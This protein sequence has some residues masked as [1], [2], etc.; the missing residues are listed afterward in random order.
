MERDIEGQA[1]YVSTTSEHEVSGWAVG[2]ITFAA[3]MMMLMG[4]FHIF[5]GL[6]G[7]FNDAFYETPREYFTEFSVSSWGWIQLVAGI[8]VFAAGVAILGGSVWARMVGVL[9]ALLSAIT[10]F[11]FLPYYPVW[12]ILMIALSIGV[13]WA[14][15]AHGRDIAEA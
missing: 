14:L 1:G 8:I 4:G 3:V 7:I 2:F 9:I 15:I 12:S 5:T 11:A 10:N 6:V 13:I